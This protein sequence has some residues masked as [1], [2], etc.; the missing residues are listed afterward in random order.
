M[1]GIPFVATKL[2]AK[3]ILL[4][5]FAVLLVIANGAFIIGR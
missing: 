4:G 5:V 1:I 2:P 3:H